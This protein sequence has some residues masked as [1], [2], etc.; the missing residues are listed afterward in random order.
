MDGVRAGRTVA[1]GVAD[2]ASGT[3]EL[4]L[5]AEVV[6][7]SDAQLDALAA[8]MKERI[9]DDTGLLPSQVV[10][11]RP[12]ALARTSSGKLMRRDA[13]DRYLAG[14]L[15]GERALRPMFAIRLV[16]AMRGILLRYLARRRAAHG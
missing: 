8:S 10:L 15:E 4:V 14:G 12:G 13:R 16:Q 3:E 9:A 11:L 5:V 1:F 7:R 6:P 2:E